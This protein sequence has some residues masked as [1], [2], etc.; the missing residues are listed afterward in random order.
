MK[1]NGLW[2][3]KG[4]M[5]VKEKEIWNG[6]GKE[7]RERIMEAGKMKEMAIWKRKK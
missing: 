2:K 7:N 5:K 1:E 4:Y 3:R 6:K